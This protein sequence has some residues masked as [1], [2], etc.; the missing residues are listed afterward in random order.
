MY[1]AGLLCKTLNDIFQNILLS[2]KCLTFRNTTENNKFADWRDATSLISNNATKQEYYGYCTLCAGNMM[3]ST[4]TLSFLLS[5]VITI[6]HKWNNVVKEV[7]RLFRQTKIISIHWRTPTWSDKVESQEFLWTPSIVNFTETLAQKIK[8][9][10]HV[11]MKTFRNHFW[12]HL[13]QQEDLLRRLLQSPAHRLP[14]QTRCRQCGRPWRGRDRRMRSSRE[15][16]VSLGC[17]QGART[18]LAEHQD[19]NSKSFDSKRLFHPFGNTGTTNKA[20]GFDWLT[21]VKCSLAAEE[22]TSLFPPSWSGS[23]GWSPG[24]LTSWPLGIATCRRPL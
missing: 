13:L 1:N 22:L 7:I 2:S 23:P 5:K 16:D 14:L 4:I 24:P 15:P 10:L 11:W 17:G 9:N 21:L 20:A 8:L 19:G 12:R 18:A 3:F 6:F